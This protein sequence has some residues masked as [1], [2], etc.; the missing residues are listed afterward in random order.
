[1]FAAAVIAL[2]HIGYEFAVG[3]ARGSKTIPIETFLKE[4][5]WIP[6][7][8]VKDGERKEVSKDVNEARDEVA[9]LPGSGFSVEVAYGVP[10]VAY[11]GA[12]YAAF[13]IYLVLFNLNAFLSL[14]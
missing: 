13:I 3:T 14:P 9:A 2:S 7:A 4:Q 10:T 1:M 6:K 11:L 8:V 12:G 5:R